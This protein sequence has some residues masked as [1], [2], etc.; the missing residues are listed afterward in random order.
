MDLAEFDINC[1]KLKN[2]LVCVGGVGSTKNAKQRSETGVIYSAITSKN[3]AKHDECTTPQAVLSVINYNFTCLPQKPFMFQRA[4]L[5]SFLWL[6][7]AA[8]R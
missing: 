7:A 4:T 3:I 6:A 5:Q 1:R 8:G 2:L